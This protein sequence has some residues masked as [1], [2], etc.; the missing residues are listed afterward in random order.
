MDGGIYEPLYA[1]LIGDLAA[2]G[3]GLGFAD[4]R[5][6]GFEVG[7]AIDFVSGTDIL[8]IAGGAV[9]MANGCGFA[10]PAPATNFS[11]WALNS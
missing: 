9:G 6:V 7:G 3:G 5:G 10:F 11:S 8:L 4:R 2:A 1:N